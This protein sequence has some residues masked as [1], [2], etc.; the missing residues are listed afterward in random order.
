MFGCLQI[1]AGSP[2]VAGSSSSK[3]NWAGEVVAAFPLSS[4]SFALSA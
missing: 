2:S 1:T 4:A 3:K